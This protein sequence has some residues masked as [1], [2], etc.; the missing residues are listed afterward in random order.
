MPSSA[1]VRSPTPWVTVPRGKPLV[2][3]AGTATYPTTGALDFTTV[4]V[5]GGPNSPVNAWDWVWG[6]LDRS[7]AVV[8][9]EELF[10]Q[11]GEQHP[12]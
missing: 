10:P 3:V 1:P 6:H 8:P 4:E 9:A 11:G 12:G 2:T 7:R 5:L